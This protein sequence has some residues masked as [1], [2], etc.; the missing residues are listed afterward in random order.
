MSMCPVLCT[1]AARRG[2][3][4][5]VHVGVAFGW[6]GRGPGCRAAP[7]AGC[8]GPGGTT[9]RRVGSRI[10]EHKDDFISRVG[11]ASGKVD[12]FRTVPFQRLGKDHVCSAPRYE[13]STSRSLHAR[14]VAE[15]L[16]PIPPSIL[17]ASRRAQLAGP[18]A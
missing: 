11:R 18:D 8:R 16:D 2:R 9:G 6:R 13:R 12:P 4:V 15:V 17:S 10:I 14:S 7:A 5:G 1:Q 3:S